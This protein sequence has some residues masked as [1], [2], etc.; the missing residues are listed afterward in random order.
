MFNGRVHDPVVSEESRYTCHSFH[1]FKPS[2][3][4][5]LIGESHRFVSSARLNITKCLLSEWSLIESANSWNDISTREHPTSWF[6]DPQEL[7]KTEK[8]LRCGDA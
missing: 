4:C 2:M 7:L 3:Y 5:I 8:G 6:S 1:E